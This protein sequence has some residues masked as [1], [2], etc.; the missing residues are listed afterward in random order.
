MRAVQLQPEIDPIGA[1]LVKAQRSDP[2]FGPIYQ[3]ML[4]AEAGDEK[5]ERNMNQLQFVMVQSVLHHIYM[6]NNRTHLD[7]SVLQI[8]LPKSMVPQILKEM[9]DAPFSGHFF[10]R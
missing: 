10:S 5:Q 9:H 7:Q 1:E 2:T 6:M 3:A 4:E 8:C